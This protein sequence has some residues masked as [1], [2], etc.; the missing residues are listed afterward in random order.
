MNQ[1]A[2]NEKS[3]VTLHFALRLEDGS[4]VDS[5]FNDK[6][7]SFN[8]GDG[9]LLPTIER[10]LLGM[11]SGDKKIFTISPED[12][13]GQRNPNNLQEFPRNN[14]SAHAD[15]APGLMLSFADANKA[16]LPGVV[17]EIH[18]D[19]VIVDFNHPLA[20]HTLNFDVEIIS[21]ERF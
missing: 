20:G 17:A 7:A 11:I 9:S 18:D 4:D 12:G 5:T 13:F 21:V 6:P 16:E 3:R 19:I 14:F 1:L 10:K 8:Y 15:L 2:I